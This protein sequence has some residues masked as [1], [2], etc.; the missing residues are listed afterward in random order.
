MMTYL[1]QKLIRFYQ[2]ILSPFL[3]GQCRY[4]PT[5]SCYAHT[6]YEKHGFCKGSILTIL[7]IL[8]CHPYSKRPWTDPVPERFALR[9]IISYKQGNNKTTASQNNNQDK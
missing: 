8:N 5:C 3:G 1:A 9:D 4:H 7:R 6:A 2:L